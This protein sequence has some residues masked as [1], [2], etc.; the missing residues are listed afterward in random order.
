MVIQL[1]RQVEKLKYFIG[2]NLFVSNCKEIMINPTSF[3]CLLF[4]N[5]AK[6]CSKLS[7]DISVLRVFQILLDTGIADNCVFWSYLPTLILR[8]IIF[9]GGCTYTFSRIPIVDSPKTSYKNNYNRE[10]RVD[11]LKT[12]KLLTLPYFYILVTAISS[13]SNKTNNNLS[14]SSRIYNVQ[15]Q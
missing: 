11:Q 2:N 12:S 4:R 9:M 3:Q 5:L 13:N 8:G 14:I 6:T 15:I 10:N 7:S 1:L